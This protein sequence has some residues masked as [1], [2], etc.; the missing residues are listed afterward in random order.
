MTLFI[1]ARIPASRLMSVYNYAIKSKKN[2]EFFSVSSILQA[3]DDMQK[4]SEQSVS[5]K[6]RDCHICNGTKKA[7]V[8]NF[9][10]GED[11]ER[12]CICAGK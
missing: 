4:Q 6:D 12:D 11:E 5:V 10:N 8:M 2:S 9:E 3:W 1:E 7:F